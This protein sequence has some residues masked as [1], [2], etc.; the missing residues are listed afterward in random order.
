MLSRAEAI[1]LVADELF[2]AWE[3]QR[4]HLDHIDCW[5]RWQ[6]EDIRLPLGATPELRHLTQLSKVPWLGLVV[7][8][9][10]Q[11][12]YVDGFRS[13]LDTQADADRD[14]TPARWTTPRRGAPGWPT[15]WTAARSR[16]TGR[17]WPTGSATPR[18]CPAA[19]R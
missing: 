6:H 9:A 14:G 16:S 2:P 11:A 12:M 17:C 4:D 8:A 15:P 1:T 13:R 18:C 5:Y 3:S 10:A 7:T 19:T